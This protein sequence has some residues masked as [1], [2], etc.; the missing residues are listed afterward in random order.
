MLRDIIFC[1]LFGLIDMV[2]CIIYILVVCQCTPSC[3]CRSIWDGMPCYIPHGGQSCLYRHLPLSFP[4]VY[5]RQMLLV[6]LQD[7]FCFPLP[8]SLPFPSGLSFWDIEVIVV[9][10]F[11]KTS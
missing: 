2:D 7:S 3:V 1:V 5:P 10:I 6:L 9:P 11:C 4:K 8:G